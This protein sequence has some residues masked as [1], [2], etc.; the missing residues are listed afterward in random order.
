MAVYEVTAS[1]TIEYDTQEGF[2]ASAEE[3]EQD[4]ID[5]LFDGKIV[6]SDYTI[7]VETVSPYDFPY[8]SDSDGDIIVLGQKY[9]I[10]MDWND[11]PTYEVTVTGGGDG[12]LT[13]PYSH[14]G[15]SLNVNSVGGFPL[16][17][18]LKIDKVTS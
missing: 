17:R 18:I 8:P 14:E 6:F 7:E 10:Q 15:R 13:G 16:D 11:H 4:M 3:A 5:L 1:V 12:M 2:V 9:E